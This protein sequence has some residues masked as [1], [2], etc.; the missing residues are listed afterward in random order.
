MVVDEAAPV[1]A[2]L[3]DRARLS[4]VSKL[5]DGGPLPIVRL[6]ADS[7]ITRQ[8]ITK[9]LHVLESVGLI[10][11]HRRGRE[12]LWELA[13]EQ[14]RSVQRNLDSIASSWDEAMSRLAAMVET[15]PAK[16]TP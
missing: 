3:G 10:R 4:I 8:A 12:C 6:A 13:P 15:E 16:E 7:G 14:L 5:C 2:A 11:G 1:F 9:H